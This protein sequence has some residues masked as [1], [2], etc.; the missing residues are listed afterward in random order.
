MRIDLGDILNEYYTENI[1]GSYEKM[2]SIISEM[3]KYI[4]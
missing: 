4:Q 3:M 2:K 1:G